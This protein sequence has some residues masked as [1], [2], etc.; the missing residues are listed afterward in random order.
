MES[1][2]EVT[3]PLIITYSLVPEALPYNVL[4][5]I[6]LLMFFQLISLFP[7]FHTVPK[8]SLLSSY[9]GSHQTVAHECVSYFNEKVMI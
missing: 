7:N 6:C 5:R 3:Q 1:Q 2:Q 8:S 9:Q 4:K